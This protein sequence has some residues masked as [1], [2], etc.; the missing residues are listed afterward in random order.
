M[1]VFFEMARL[2]V[3]Y[4]KTDT[5]FRGTKGEPDMYFNDGIPRCLLCPFLPTSSIVGVLVIGWLAVL[6][7]VFG[8]SFLDVCT[9]V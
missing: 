6:L 5:H 2:M 4:L 9:R 8:L 1:A 3:L 7:C